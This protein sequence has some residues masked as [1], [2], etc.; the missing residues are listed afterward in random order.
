MPKVQQLSGLL[1]IIIRSGDGLA[2]KGVP[3]EELPALAKQSMVLPDY[4]SNPRVVESEEEM[5]EL[6][7]QC[8]RR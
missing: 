1:R 5:L 6:L 3:E 7:Q 4:E 8:Y 2:D